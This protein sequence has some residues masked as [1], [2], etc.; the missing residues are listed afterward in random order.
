[1]SAIDNYIGLDKRLTMKQWKEIGRDR[2]I[3]RLTAAIEKLR[4]HDFMPGMATSVVRL[5]ML[6]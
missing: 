1:M 3:R 4:D 5:E 6:S 2:T